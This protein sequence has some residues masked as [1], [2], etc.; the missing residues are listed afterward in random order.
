MTANSLSLPAVQTPDD[1]EIDRQLWA[2]YS[3]I[4]SLGRRRKERLARLAAEAA[5]IADG[6]TK[7]GEVCD[8]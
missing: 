3:Y 6:D 8:A 4:L 7:T 5:A 2:A 1:A